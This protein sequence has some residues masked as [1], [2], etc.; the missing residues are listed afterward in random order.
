MKLN[1]ES[2]VIILLI[3]VLTVT[4]VLIT[5]NPGTPLGLREGIVA[6]VN[7]EEIREEEY[8]KLLDYYLSEL[9]ASYDLT[10]DTLNKDI[11]T[12]MTF[13][14]SL[15]L[16]VLDTII[17]NRIIAEKATSNNIGVDEEELQELYEENHLGLMEEDE[18]YK[19]MIEENK[20]DEDFIMDQMRK[21]LLSYKYKVFYLDKVE[22]S[23][24]AAKTFYDENN[25]RFHLEEI[26]ARHILV[27]EEE[28]ARDIIKKL[29]EGEDFVELAKEYSTEPNAEERG[30]DLGYFTRDA[31]FVPEFKEAAFALEVGKVSEPIK[32]EFG[33]HV[34]TVE[35]KIEEHVEFE[36]AKEGIKYSLREMDYQNHISEIFEEADIIKRDEL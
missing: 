10:D 29:E 20:I 28:T 16:E 11:G 6:T 12:G 23:D 1:T 17:I 35:D 3:V 22:I 24:E 25:D 15:K 32:T 19:K 33:Y 14:D 4:A 9:R 7:G 27:D 36:N 5:I 26:R 8:N 18:D 21:N 30:G 13:L 2:V 31:N 34:I